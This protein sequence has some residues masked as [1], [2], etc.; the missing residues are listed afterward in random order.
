MGKH[1]RLTFLMLSYVSP[2]HPALIYI[3]ADKAFS[4]CYCVFV[5]SR[6]L[7]F[8]CWLMRHFLYVLL[9]VCAVPPAVLVRILAGAAFSL[10]WCV[11]MPSPPAISASTFSVPLPC[12]FFPTANPRHP[13]QNVHMLRS[14][15]KSAF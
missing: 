12:L 14:A 9:C 2:P 8:T 15:C 11:F 1:T 10:C 13:C 6:R 3:L 4:L 7:W 5:P